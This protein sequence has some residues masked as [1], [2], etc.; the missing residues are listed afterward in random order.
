MPSGGHPQYQDF[1][2][3]KKPLWNKFKRKIKKPIN[4]IAGDINFVNHRLS[5]RQYTYTNILL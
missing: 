3:Q 1:H 2:L 5:K 4:I